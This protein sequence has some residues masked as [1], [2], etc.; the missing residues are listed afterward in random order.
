MNQ[1]EYNFKGAIGTMVV[2]VDGNQPVSATSLKVVVDDTVDVKAGNVVTPTITQPGYS[3]ET[4]TMILEGR[5]YKVI[6]G[7]QVDLRTGEPVVKDVT[8]H[9]LPKY[10]PGSGIGEQ[11][12]NLRQWMFDNPWFHNVVNIDGSVDPDLNRYQ[13]P[14]LPMAYYGTATGNLT[15]RA[16]VLEHPPVKVPV[17]NVPPAMARDK[18]TIE[19]G[20]V[21]YP[22]FQV[23]LYAPAAQGQDTVH[24]SFTTP[25]TIGTKTPGRID[26]AEFPGGPCPKSITIAGVYTPADPYGAAPRVDLGTDAVLAPSTKYDVYVTNHGA[27]GDSNPMKIIF[28]SPK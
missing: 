25:A 15:L 7:V 13:D 27:A 12:N 6:N 24:F 9:E 18:T 2:K 1:T 21:P 20:E 17:V 19:L 16:D 28:A 22:E 5:F 8:T 10:F 4:A 14:A 26:A 11:V 3:S 23:E